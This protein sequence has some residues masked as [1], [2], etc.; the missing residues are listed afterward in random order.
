MK[1]LDLLSLVVVVRTNS[2]TQYDWYKLELGAIRMKMIAIIVGINP[3]LDLIDRN[4]A[5]PLVGDLDVVPLLPNPFMERCRAALVNFRG[6]V[7]GV[8][9]TTARHAMV[10]VWSLYPAVSL[11]VVDTRFAD[12]IE[13][14]EA[15]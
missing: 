7:H 12:G 1:V 9:C 8:A 2:R 4:L 5:P 10:F 15:E 11:E 14:D 13:D 3:V 6:Y